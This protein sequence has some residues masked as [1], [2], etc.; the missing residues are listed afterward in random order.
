MSLS[1]G[2]FAYRGNDIIKFS[3][4]CVR[5]SEVS[6]FSDKIKEPTALIIALNRII[7]DGNFRANCDLV[8]VAPEIHFSGGVM[9]LSGVNGENGEPACPI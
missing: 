5:T 4:G 8:L 7:V 9:D 3:G 1:S 2:T 6:K